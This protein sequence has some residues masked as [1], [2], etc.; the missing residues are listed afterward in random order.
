MRFATSHDGGVRFEQAHQLGGSRD[1]LAVE[2][3]S[4]G[5]SDDLLYQ[6]RSA[7]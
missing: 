5:L 6:R 4:L 7:P 2:H 1:A 3:P